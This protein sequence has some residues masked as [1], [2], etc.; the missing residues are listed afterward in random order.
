RRNT[1]GQTLMGAVVGQANIPF[2]GKLYRLTRKNF[3]GNLEAMLAMCRRAGV[4]VVL[5]RLVSNVKDLPPLSQI[6]PADLTPPL[7]A[8]RDSLY[9]EGKRELGKNAAGKALLALRAAAEIDSLHPGICYFLGR[10]LLATGQPRRAAHWLRRARDLDGLRF[11]ATGDFSLLID[12]LARAFRLPVVDMPAVFARHSPHGIPGDELICD[13]LHPNPDGYF[14]MARAFYQTLVRSHLL[15]AA[16]R[17]FQMPNHPVFVT[18]LDWNIGLV[19]IFP[20]MRRW[21]FPTRPVDWQEFQPYGDPYSAQ[22]ARWYVFEENI[23]S[24]AHYR[25]AEHYQKQGQLDRALREYQAVHFYAPLELYP[26]LRLV[27]LT[28]KLQDWPAQA[29]YLR[30]ALQL[31]PKKA[32]LYYQLALNLWHQQNYP[33]AIRMMEKVLRQPEFTPQQRQNAW[34]YLAGFYVDAGRPER[35][36]AILK[37]LLRASPNFKPARQFLDQLLH[38]KG[39]SKR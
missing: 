5:S 14:L 24:K 11:R 17:H 9:D 12:S 3:A 19:K 35:A 23:W 22:I 38:G 30:Q 16:P 15:R 6:S 34:F 27:D 37:M 13:H 29:A 36:V 28:G 1:S 4:P 2:Q 21:P 20:M 7:L 26:I 18:D 33:A 31:S 25:M 39:L 32:L 8:A 10:A